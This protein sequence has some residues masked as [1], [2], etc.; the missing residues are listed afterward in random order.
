MEECVLACVYVRD[1]DSW[2]CQSSRGTDHSIPLLLPLLPLMLPQIFPHRP[3]F[4]FSQGA[5]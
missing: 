4:F 5:L 1:G 2:A 3:H